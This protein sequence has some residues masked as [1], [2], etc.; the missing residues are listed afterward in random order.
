M[1]MWKHQ[2]SLPACSSDIHLDFGE[3]LMYINVSV[4]QLGSL[5]RLETQEATFLHF[6]SAGLLNICHHRC[7]LKKGEMDVKDSQI[8]ARALQVFFVFCFYVS[9]S[10]CY[11]SCVSQFLETTGHL[12]QGY[13]N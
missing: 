11:S 6:V 1:S 8:L 9:T 5:T 2:R 12:N 3:R 13:L 10:V 4:I 7:F